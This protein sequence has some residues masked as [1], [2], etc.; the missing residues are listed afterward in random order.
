M[1]STITK[2]PWYMSG[3]I[4]VR[5]RYAV[6]KATVDLIRLLQTAI[7]DHR[8]EQQLTPQLLKRLYIA[9][10]LCPGFTATMK[11]DIAYMVGLSDETQQGFNQPRFADCWRHAYSLA[12]KP[13]I[14]LDVL[15]VRISTLSE[16]TI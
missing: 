14:P 8:Q 7:K 11:D 10:M 16:V 13:G 15:E 9:G 2:L 6:Y 3:Y 1:I 12:P 4:T 5:Q